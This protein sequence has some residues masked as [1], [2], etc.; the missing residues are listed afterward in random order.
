MSND[1]W[2]VILIIGLVGWIFSGIMLML[3]AFPQKDVFVLSSG[4]RW[5]LA[6]LISFFIWI[7]GMLK[8]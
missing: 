7:I 8:A 6:V 1:L 5:G 3:K 4:I 2:S